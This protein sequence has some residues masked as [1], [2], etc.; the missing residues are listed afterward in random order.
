MG[1][2]CSGFDKD[3]A[4]TSVSVVIDDSHPLVKLAN[5][6]PWEDILAVVTPDLQQTEK[7]KWWVGRPLRVR[8]HLGV[9]LLQQMYNLTDRQA[10][11]AVKDNAAFQLFCGRNIVDSW[12]CPD[13]T[14]IES[15]RSRLS[16][17][18][19]RKIANLMASV[20]VKNNYACPKSVDIDSTVQEANITPPSKPKLLLKIALLAKKVGGYLAEFTGNR[21]FKYQVKCGNLRRMIL[22]YYTIMRKRQDSGNAR[23]KLLQRMWRDVAA[24]VIPIA[25]AA[26]QLLA[27]CPLNKYWHIRYAV[28]QLLWRGMKVLEAM[29]QQL[30]TD[31]ECDGWIHSLHAYEVAAFNKNKIVKGVQY[32]RA[33]QVGRVEGNFAFVAKN[34]S[35]KMYDAQ[36]LPAIIHE[37]GKIFD[38]TQIESLAI[39]RGYYSNDNKKFLDDSSVKEFLLPKPSHS[40]GPLSKP[41]LTPDRALELHNRRSG[42]EAIIS[43]I[44]HGGQM[45]RSRMK[46]DNTTLAAGYASVLG[47]NLRQLKRYAMGVV[48][49]K[50]GHLAQMA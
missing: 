1:F 29:H 37:H 2:D 35:L 8:I 44:K 19:Q 22:F 45:R 48:H 4:G 30:F 46:S 10:E 18:T 39:D 12:N 27:L 11:Y 23:L 20:A 14:K 17:E 16:P 43:H 15:F 40:R 5:K 38:G 31:D 41:T 13:H 21:E 3:I 28:E 26:H 42:I 6:L 36:S 34:E 50:D 32:G 33:F 24:M 7:L 9:Y 25:N 49:P 47:F